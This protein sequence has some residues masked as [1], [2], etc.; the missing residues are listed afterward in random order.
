MKK[1]QAAR[2]HFAGAL[3][4]VA[5]VFTVALMDVRQAAQADNTG[6]PDFLVL[7]PENE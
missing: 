1:K 3:A 4:L 5:L 7:N 2:Q 6:D